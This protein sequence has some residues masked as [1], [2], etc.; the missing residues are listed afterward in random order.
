MLQLVCDVDAEFRGTLF[1]DERRIRW[2]TRLEPCGISI[3]RWPVAGRR[4]V[5]KF[6]ENIYSCHYGSVITEHFP[7]LMS[8]YD[9]RG[10]IL[11]AVGV[12]MAADERLFLEQYLDRPIESALA[13][14]SMQPIERARII[15]IGNLACAGKGAS[16][17][18]FIAL[19][20]YLRELRQAYAVV[21]ATAGL[22]WILTSFGIRFVHLAAARSSA[23]ADGGSSWG[24]YY[25]C[26]PQII[27]LAIP[28][29]FA[30]LEPCLPASHNGDLARLFNRVSLPT[31]L[32]VA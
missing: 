13:A 27:A 1:V 8:V 19:A 21:T 5:E 22:R 20:A 14:V 25:T 7:T 30:R 23:L 11:A 17:F 29:A 31:P 10:R 3:V 9:R 4:R 16:V 2:M 18:L 28:W 32:G 24:S 6:I 15:E 12:R 26:D